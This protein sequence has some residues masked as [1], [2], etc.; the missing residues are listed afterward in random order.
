MSDHAFS[1]REFIDAKRLAAARCAVVDDDPSI[2][3]AVAQILDGE[4]YQPECYRDGSEALEQ[5]RI[6]QP[7]LALVDLM[8]PQM[9]GMEL[10][11]KIRERWVFPV[12]ML[13]AR[14]EELDEVLSLRLGADDFVRKPFSQRLLIERVRAGLRRAKL[15][16]SE[17]PA[18]DHDHGE[19][20]EDVMRRGPL[21]MD[22]GR[23][24]ARWRGKEVALT[25]TEFNL[26]AALARHP[27]YVKNRDQLMSVAYDQQVFVDDR[28][29]DSHI[30]RLRKK[31]R[32]IDPNFQ[33][34][35]TLYGVGYKYL[36]ITH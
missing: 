19:S 35:E 22:S 29:I 17:P 13:T 36:P 1:A 9:D 24:L 2:L 32:A 34:I 31:M 28:T 5:F 18:Q 4:G 30:K 27:G 7:D 26:L 6:K 14:C 8:M 12:I 10:I 16:H 33:A 20:A 21:E 25:V 23:H 11:R 15:S 3:E